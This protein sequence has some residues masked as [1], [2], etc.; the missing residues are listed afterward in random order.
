MGFLRMYDP[1]EVLA[2]CV[3]VEPYNLCPSNI[4]LCGS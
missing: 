1:L 3:N 4:T 2:H